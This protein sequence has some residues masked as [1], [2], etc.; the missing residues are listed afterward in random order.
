MPANAA[1]VTAGILADMPVR[2]LIEGAL[3]AQILAA[4]TA[5]GIIV[6]PPQFDDIPVGEKP[7]DK[8]STALEAIILDALRGY[9]ISVGVGVAAGVV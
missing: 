3:Q 5:A 7:W 8:F 4:A 1:V 6:S 9:A 2:G